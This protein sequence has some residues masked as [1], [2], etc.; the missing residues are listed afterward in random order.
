MYNEFDSF[1]RAPRR[2][3]LPAVLITIAIT[4]FV[5]VLLTWGIQRLTTARAVKN[6]GSRSYNRKL[7]EIQAYIDS[8]Y[9]GQ[10]DDEEMEDALAAG[11][12]DGLGDEWSYYMTADSYD[13]YKENMANA[14]VGIGVTITT[15]NIPRG[16]SITEVTPGGPAEVAGLLP[17]DLIVAVDGMPVLDGTPD[18]LDM[19]GT[20]NRVRGE[21]GT[22]VVLTIER[23]GV[24]KDY[25]LVR[26]AIKSVNVTMETVDGDLAY[27]R[28]RNFETNAAQDVIEAIDAAQANGAKGIIFDVRY[29]PGGLKRELVSLLDY[30]LPEGALFRSVDYTGQENVDYSDAAHIEIP[31][32]VLVNYN[33]YSASEFFAAALQEY[34]YAKIVGE[35]TYGKG[36]FQSAFQ[37]SDGSAINLSIGKYTTPNGVSLVGKGVTPDVP[38]ALTDAE[39]S[40]FYYGRLAKEDDDQLT[41]AISLLDPSYD[42]SAAA[43]QQ[44]DKTEPEPQPEPEPR[45]DA[46]HAYEKKLQEIQSY[47][48]AYFIG[49]VDEQALADSAA[50][51]LIDGLGDEW[52]YYISAEDYDFYQE[53][54]SNSY[55]GIGVTITSEGVEQ[56]LQIT[57]VT[58]DSP[59]YRAGLQIGDLMTAVEGVPIRDGSEEALD[60]N[61]TRNR[62]R[63]EAGTNVT[64]TIERD[65]VRTDYTITRASIKVVN[66]SCEP[67]EDGIYYIRIR[68]FD[69]NAAADSIAA[70]E[71]ARAAGAEGIIFDV[72]YNPGGYKRELVELLDYLL[73]EGPLFRSITRSGSEQVDYSDEAHIEIPMAVLVNYDSYSAAEFFAA[74][75]QEYDAAVI[76]GVQTYGKG[77][78]QNTFPLTDGSAINISVG[79]YTTPKGVSLVGKGITPD[80]V[81][82]ITDDEKMDL[83]YGRMEKDAD[84]QLKKAVEVLTNSLP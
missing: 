38:V 37:L 17:G 44:D 30:I 48:D 8:Y 50:E 3:L 42:P 47:I 4:A 11:M 20:K 2:R 45:T 25:S 61:E 76:V 21:A 34:G 16:V 36:Y 83:Y 65:G 40:D 54:V 52:S 69:E 19:D 18:S 23:D 63:G 57:D 66:V 77:Y 53:T 41:A 10:V 70:I 75:L 5:T 80:H 27:I 1:D 28:I 67:L 71:E 14:Y 64:V 39:K 15:Q 35:Q 46:G 6:N 51:G 82:E 12:I 78:F 81:V 33:S 73:P 29:N 26:A 59:A 68:N 13:S 79:R 55:V 62:V 9:I 24:S 58:P 72:R 22:S 56:G 60:I 31:M 43:P 7:Q 84:E 32:A 74:A 49:D